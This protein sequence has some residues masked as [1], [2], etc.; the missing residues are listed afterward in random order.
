MPQQL[1]GPNEKARFSDSIRRYIRIGTLTCLILVVGFGGWAATAKLSSAVIS[2]GRIVVESNVKL[3]QHQDGGIVGEIYVTD[4]D[5]VTAGELVITLD[6]TL[7]AANR[8]LLDGQIIAMEARLARLEAEQIE[9][10]SITIP[11]EMLDRAEERLVTQAM[12]SEKTVF[13]ARRK[14]MKGQ[15][16]RLNE[17]IGQL[18]EQISGL[19]AQRDAKAGEIDLIDTELDVLGDLFDRGRTTR[20]RI[21]NLQRNRMRLEGER[22]SLVSQIAVAKGRI[23]ETQ[24]EILQLTTDRRE[25]TFSEI[26]EIRP[27]LANLKERRAAADFQLKR[28][29][30]RAPAT[31][32]VHQLAVHTVDGVIQPGEVIMQIV[33]DD[34]VLVIEAQVAPTDVNDVAVGQDTTIVLPAFDF[35]TTPQLHGEVTFVSAEASIDEVSGLP[36]YRVRVSP[37]PGELER[38][39]PDKV[40]I[41]GMPAETYISTGGQTV[42][43]YLMKPL[44]AQIRKAWRET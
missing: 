13:E 33:P 37:N 24:L 5:Q 22:G 9:A 31:G 38:L 2:T 39:G 43:S 20:D 25:Q 27:E 44:T 16:D 3:V 10:D 18:N 40:L 23:N 11:D 42:V 28:M 30:I 35:K 21:V 14:T 36:Y 8:A 17:R 19:E 29:D 4:G 32:T 1:A 12:S 41:P 26:T 6:E 7:V 15:E 34:D